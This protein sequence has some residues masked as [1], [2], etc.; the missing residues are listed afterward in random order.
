MNIHPPCSV[1]TDR[2]TNKPKQN[3]R[4]M[5]LTAIMKQTTKQLQGGTSIAAQDLNF[6]SLV[7]VT[8]TILWTDCQTHRRIS[9]FLPTAVS[10]DAIA[11]PLER[12]CKS[13]SQE[14]RVPGPSDS[15]NRMILRSL[16]LTHYQLVT[17][18][19]TDRRTDGH[20][21]LQHSCC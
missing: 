11:I 5:I 20:V 14:T 18:R 16:V 2:Q 4:N 17:E 9:P 19:Q 6:W 7:E 13:W 10:F 12:R 21:A 8:R 3:I 15:K 1:L